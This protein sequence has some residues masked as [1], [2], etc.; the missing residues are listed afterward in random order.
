M[1]CR[2]L[3]AYSASPDDPNEVS[4]GKGEIIEIIDSSGKWWQCK[5]SAGQV[6]S[7]CLEQFRTHEG[8]LGT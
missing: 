2:A 5:T 3:Y 1:S 8:K 4:F 7:E 6:G